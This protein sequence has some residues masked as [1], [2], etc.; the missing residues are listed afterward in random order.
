MHDPLHV[1]ARVVDALTR[2][3]R[4]RPPHY[5]VLRCLATSTEPRSLTELA[6]G[7]PEWV[8]ALVLDTLEARGLVERQG[9]G[10]TL[11]DAGRAHWSEDWVHPA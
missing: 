9:D 1:L 2:M 4:E 11:S 10:W 6:Q 7:G 8:T 5:S 3:T